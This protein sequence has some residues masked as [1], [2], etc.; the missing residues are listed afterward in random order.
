MR[1]VPWAQEA[2]VVSRREARRGMKGVEGFMVAAVEWV[3]CS[4][5]IQRNLS[6]SMSWKA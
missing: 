4:E 1:V 2:R 6:K 5:G 3:G